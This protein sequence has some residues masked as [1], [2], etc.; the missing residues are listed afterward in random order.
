MIGLLVSI[1]SLAEAKVTLGSNVRIIDIK[2][3]N[4]GALGCV[5]AKTLEEIADYLAE[6]RD[7]QIGHGHA[8]NQSASQA[9]SEPEQQFAISAALGE[10]L[11]LEEHAPILRQ[12]CLERVDF[13]KLGLAQLRNKKH[14]WK[15]WESKIS[16]LPSHIQSVAVAYADHITC[17]SPSPSDVATVGMQLG[18]SFV[19]L[20]TFCKQK[21]SV[22]HHMPENT[23]SKFIEDCKQNGQQVVLAGSLSPAT[24]EKAVTCAPDFIGVRGA[25]CLSD[26]A[27]TVCENRLASVANQLVNIQRN[28]PT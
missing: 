10:A 2:E 20:D 9:N 6:S 11:A 4:N 17:N 25:I 23:T 27:S 24:M 15:I 14:W 1:R 19:L 18:C 22:F 7:S 26:R 21:G 13:A 5:D 16:L 28:L 12:H 8:V 3:P